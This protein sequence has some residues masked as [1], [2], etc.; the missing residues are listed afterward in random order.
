MFNIVFKCDTAK[1]TIDG[2]WFDI[3]KSDG[4]PRALPFKYRRDVDGKHW[5]GLVCVC[6]GSLR[7]DNTLILL[8]HNKITGFGN[9]CVG[10]FFISADLTDSVQGIWSGTKSY[11]I[12]KIFNNCTVQE[13]KKRLRD[14]TAMNLSVDNED[15]ELTLECLKT[16]NFD[17]ENVKSLNKKRFFYTRVYSLK[18][19][20]RLFLDAKRASEEEERK[21]EFSNDIKEC[22]EMLIR[23]QIQLKSIVYRQMKYQRMYNNDQTLIQQFEQFKPLF[24][25]V[26]VSDRDKAIISASFKKLK[27]QQKTK[28]LKELDKRQTSGCPFGITKDNVNFISLTNDGYALLK[29]YIE[30]S[31]KKT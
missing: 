28:I 21:A 3:D 30:I 2:M 10:R 15:S 26:F 14:A 23:Q 27:Q 25:N 13:T 8:K 22:N 16:Q 20:K 6:N 24:N 31:Q 12:D 4:E 1:G 11:T 29:R 5:T 17:F 18:H 9:N 19:R 7:E